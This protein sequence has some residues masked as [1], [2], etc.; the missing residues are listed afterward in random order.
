MTT[1]ELNKKKLALIAWI[2]TLSDERTIDF[3]ESIKSSGSNGDWWDEL[4]IS[5]Q[6]SIRTGID[7]IKKG[8]VISRSEF[9]N[10]LKDG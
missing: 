10:S 4:S 3:L 9:W 7:D 1:A 8:D 5:Q 2:N 6:K